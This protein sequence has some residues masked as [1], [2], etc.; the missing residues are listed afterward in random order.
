MQINLNCSTCAFFGFT[1]RFG[2][3]QVLL[4][5][6][7][8]WELQCFHMT[9]LL[10]DCVYLSTCET[11][12]AACIITIHAA[13]SQ[14]KWISCSSE[15][16]HISPKARDNCQIHQCYNLVKK[17]CLALFVFFPL[18]MAGWLLDL[19]CSLQPLQ[20]SEFYFKHTLNAE[21]ENLQFTVVLSFVH[22]VRPSLPCR[23]NQNT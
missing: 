20:P 14:T 1:Q 16:E 18:H 17:H 8:F 23:T 5:A 19:G 9:A 2:S 11:V 15:I 13:V 6:K 21:A 12:W 10:Y 22:T 7:R 4:N 3:A